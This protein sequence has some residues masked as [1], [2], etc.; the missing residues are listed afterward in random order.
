M[1][2]AK[3]SAEEASVAYAAY[4]Y[5]LARAYAT[6][7]DAYAAYRAARRDA[8]SAYSAAEEVTR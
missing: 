1:T 2:T 4:R 7:L 3:A 8:W 6:H 5:T